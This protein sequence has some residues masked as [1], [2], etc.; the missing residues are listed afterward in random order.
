MSFLG[1]GGGLSIHDIVYFLLMFR[2]AMLTSRKIYF[3]NFAMKLGKGII[4]IDNTVTG[5]IKKRNPALMLY[6][7]DKTNF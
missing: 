4:E 5:C 7:L 3:A 2:M 6:N 1:G